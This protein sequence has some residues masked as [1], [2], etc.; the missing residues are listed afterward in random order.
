MRK[1]FKNLVF[2]NEPDETTPISAENLNLIQANI[3]NAL[4]DKFDYNVTVVTD[5]NNIKG[6]GIYMIRSDASNLPFN[7]STI[8]SSGNLAWLI[9]ISSNSN[10]INPIMQI[11]FESGS[12]DF[13]IRKSNEYEEGSWS[14]WKQIT[15]PDREIVTLSRDRGNFNITTAWSPIKI[16][17]INSNFS[18]NDG[19]LIFENGGIT[20]G[21]NVNKILINANIGGASRGDGGDKILQLF[22]NNY[23]NLIAESYVSGSNPANWQFLS[24]PPILI[25]VEEN[26]II[27]CSL[28][29]GLVQKIEFLFSYM[30]IEI[31]D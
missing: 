29:C 6:A 23:E 22:K 14:A 1:Q 5:A 19:R 9:V 4:R 30:T 31:V 21:K 27:F 26:D 25:D 10:S 8:V 17:F 7:V 2:K 3:E 18:Y 12:Y 20:I 13:W 15:K 28:Q 24:I 11:A 16:E